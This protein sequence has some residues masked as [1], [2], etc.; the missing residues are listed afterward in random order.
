MSLDPNYEER[1]R[2]LQDQVCRAQTIT[3]GLM[4]GRDRKFVLHRGTAFAAT[5]LPDRAV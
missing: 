1:L 4:S 2:E 5:I 3:P